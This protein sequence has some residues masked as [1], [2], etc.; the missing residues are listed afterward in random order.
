[1]VRLILPDEPPTFTPEA[2][3][4]LLRILLAAQDAAHLDEIAGDGAEP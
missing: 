1:V 2:A 3:R 4:A